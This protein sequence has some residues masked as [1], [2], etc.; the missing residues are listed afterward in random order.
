M[1]RTLKNSILATCY[2][3]QGKVILASELTYASES[4]VSTLLAGPPA[5]SHIS[6]NQVLDVQLPSS[7]PVVFLKREGDTYWHYEGRGNDC[8]WCW[9]DDWLPCPHEPT[10]TE[11]TRSDCFQAPSSF[12]IPTFIPRL[13]QQ[14]S[15]PQARYLLYIKTSKNQVHADQGNRMQSKAMYNLPPTYFHYKI[16]WPTMITITKTLRSAD[17]K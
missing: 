16:R 10:E 8:G 15:T 9:R 17:N 14:Q 5:T 3:V 1:A 11:S 2:N 6:T 4:A 7:H 12:A 13:V